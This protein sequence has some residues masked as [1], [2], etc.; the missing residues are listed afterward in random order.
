VLCCGRV[1]RPRM[2]NR[3][4]NQVQKSRRDAGG[5]EVQWRIQWAAESGAVGCFWKTQAPAGGQRYERQMPA[6]RE[7]LW[8][9]ALYWRVERARHAVPL[10][11]GPRRAK[12][13]R[14]A[15]LLLMDD[16]AGWP[17]GS[18]T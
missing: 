2:V 7:F 15:R 4:R 6:L 3:G 11:K 12:T 9:A 13:K 17:G 8:W 18:V 16:N 5:T 1:D 10:L 14:V